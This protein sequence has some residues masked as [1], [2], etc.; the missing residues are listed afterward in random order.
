ML[1]RAFRPRVLAYAAVLGT[2]ILAAAISLYAR[3]PLKVDVIR[4]RASLS[5]EV[6][7]GMTENVFRLQI[8]NT[9]EVAHRYRISV[10]GL[11]RLRVAD[12]GIVEVPAATAIMVP[13]RLRVES[14]TA[15]AGSHRI[16]FLVHALEDE[17]IMAREQS[18][19]LIR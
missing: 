2:I 5:R 16:E 9:E 13:I 11:P 7:G 3:V 14:A 15:G 4:D 17:R 6:E 1:R 12:E 19:F 18:M 8:M 10:G